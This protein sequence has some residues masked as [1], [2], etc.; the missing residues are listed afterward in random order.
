MI[1]KKRR[2]FILAALLAALALSSPAAAAVSDAQLEQ[3]L[4]DLSALRTE[5]AQLRLEVR[6]L[7]AAA[8]GQSANTGR[9]ANAA[10]VPSQTAPTDGPMEDE[11]M[12]G[13]FRSFMRKMLNYAIKELDEGAE[14]PAN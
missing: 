8:E 7:Q 6:R 12:Q 13:I 3:M 11:E 10:A 9:R 2:A 5:V 14:T 1:V 4:R